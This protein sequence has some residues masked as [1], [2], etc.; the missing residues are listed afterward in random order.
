MDRALHREQEVR[1]LT[2]EF[3]ALQ[4][5][6]AKREEASEVG[7][8]RATQ[9]VEQEREGLEPG[10]IANDARC[11]AGPS[12]P[13]HG[14]MSRPKADLTPPQEHRGAERF[15]RKGQPRREGQRVTRAA[16]SDLRLELAGKEQRQS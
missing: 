7:R 3:V 4:V 8:E 11:C 12:Q 14:S 10:E 13:T 1:Q 6:V 5:E 15:Q 9:R 2:G 16:L